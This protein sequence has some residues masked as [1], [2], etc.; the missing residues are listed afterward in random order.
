MGS[1]KL[2]N[3]ILWGGGG[4]MVRGGVVEAKSGKPNNTGE[5]VHGVEVLKLVLILYECVSD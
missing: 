3:L 1:E 4:R 2:K 5:G